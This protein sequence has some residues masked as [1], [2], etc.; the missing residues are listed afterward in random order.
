LHAF[1]D[2]CTQFTNWL[3]AARERLAKCTAQVNDEPDILKTKAT[4]LNQLEQDLP[5]GREKLRHA[6]RCCEIAKA[7]LS[8]PNQEQLD[9]QLGHLQNELEAFEESLRDLKRSLEVD[10]TKWDEYERQYRKC[11]A[12]ITET[13]PKVDEFQQLQP[14]LMTK[15]AKLEEFQTLFQSL[16]EWK[17]EFDKLNVKAQLLIETYPNTSIS[18]AYNGLMNRYSD[19]VTN[20]KQILRLLERRFQEHQQQQQ[21]ISECQ[22]MIEHKNVNF[23]D[24]SKGLLHS[25][26]ELETRLRALHSIEQNL[27]QSGEHKVNY[28][29]ELTAKLIEST[30]PAG[31]DTITSYANQ[32]KT[33]FDELTTRVT[34]LKVKVCDRLRRLSQLDDNDNI[35]IEP[36]THQKSFV[37]DVVKQMPPATSTTTTTMAPSTSIGE[38]SVKSKTTPTSTGPASSSSSSPASSAQSTPSHRLHQTKTSSS[39]SPTSAALHPQTSSPMSAPGTTPGSQADVTEDEELFAEELL[40][41]SGSQMIDASQKSSQR[42]APPSASSTH[43]SH[44]QDGTQQ[45]QSKSPESSSSSKKP[46]RTRDSEDLSYIDDTTTTATTKSS[47]IAPPVSFESKDEFNQWSAEMEAKL[48]AINEDEEG[49]SSDMLSIN[50]NNLLELTLELERVSKSIEDEER[51]QKILAILAICGQKASAIRAKLNDVSV[52]PPTLMSYLSR[53]VIVTVIF[54]ILHLFH[55]PDVDLFPIL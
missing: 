33:S 31:I 13:E 10:L 2:S 51:R 38:T 43:R 11:Y 42:T 21:M 20:A 28:A 19:L 15:R 48:L 47:T 27:K 9:E 29:M 4:I 54:I 17:T 5:D 26:D 39:S 34:E 32:M 7:A 23:E 44:S 14:D 12:W 45:Q 22:D 25:L 46:P 36:L 30:A 3:T 16:F 50:L 41:S 18:K 1:H 35:V 24:V 8:E 49:Q 40:T 53:D 55:I 52:R 37:D 6:L